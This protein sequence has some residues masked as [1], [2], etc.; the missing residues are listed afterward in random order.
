MRDNEEGEDEDDDNDEFFYNFHPFHFDF[1]GSR[2]YNESGATLDRIT[3]E[4]SAIRKASYLCDE[5]HW[6]FTRYSKL[7]PVS[8]K[9]KLSGVASWRLSR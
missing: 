2:H 9:L 3:E 1:S 7:H 4:D 8:D 5:M 6:E